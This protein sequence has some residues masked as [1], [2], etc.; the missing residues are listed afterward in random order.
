MVVLR[1][2]EVGVA[3]VKR[4][5][6]RVKQEGMG[7]GSQALES[8]FLNGI[9]S[10]QLCQLEIPLAPNNRKP[11]LMRLIHIYKAQHIVSTKRKG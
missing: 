3:K 6:G 2:I 5:K 1:N 7:L 10:S 11:T 8:D 9:L 4:A